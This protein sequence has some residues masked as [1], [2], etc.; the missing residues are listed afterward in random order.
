LEEPGEG[1]T[2]KSIREQLSAHSRSPSCASC[3]QRI[4]PLGFA[5]ENYDV[6]GRWRDRDRGVPVDATGRLPDGTHLDGPAS[7]QAALLE[8]K[9][10]FLR[11]LAKRLLGYALGRGL[12][13]SDTCAAESIVT[14][15]ESQRYSAWALLR[16]VVRS[17][18]FLHVAGPA[19]GP[20]RH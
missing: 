13:T 19:Q 5:L 1:K 7:L 10:L 20:E 11:N 9:H 12:T 18:P 8:R 2:V 14:Q 3:H 4:D 6:L 15:V 17:E 16:E